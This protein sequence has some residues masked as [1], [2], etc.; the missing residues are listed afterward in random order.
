MRTQLK[1]FSVTVM[2]ALIFSTA[3]L[4]CTNILIEYL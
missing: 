4:L 1:I 3:L 2:G